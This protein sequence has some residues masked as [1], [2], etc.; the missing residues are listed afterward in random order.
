MF[1]AT[2]P[3]EHFGPSLHGDALVDSQHGETYVVKV[4]DAFVGTFPVRST[5]RAVYYAA[6]AVT[7]L[8]T[9][10]RLLTLCYGIEV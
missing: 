7:S 10:S 8:G 2:D 9:G 1:A 6:S 5:L 3:V 4:S